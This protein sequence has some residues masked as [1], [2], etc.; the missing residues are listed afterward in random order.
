MDEPK[1]YHIIKGKLVEIKSAIFAN[2]DTY[3]V[4]DPVNKVIWIWIG[5]KSTIDEKFAAAQISQ[6]ELLKDH[7]NYEVKSID[8]G[9]EPDE[10]LDLFGESIQFV[11][12]DVHGMLKHHEK[13]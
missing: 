9:N 3:I 4:E 2:G 1:I 8:E 12:G 13:K 10:F 11:E 5:S 6:N 7:L